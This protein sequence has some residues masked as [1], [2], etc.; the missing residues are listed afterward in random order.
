MLVIHD[1]DGSPYPVEAALARAGFEVTRVRGLTDALR[2]FAGREPDAILVDLAAPLALEA[3]RRLRRSWSAPMIVATDRDSEFD[4]AVVLEV[5]A[6][7]CVARPLDIRE[8]LARIAALLRRVGTPRQQVLTA[9]RI[10]IDM[11]AHRV[12][13]GTEEV[14]LT[15]NE[16]ALLSTLVASTGRV[17][18]R[19]ELQKRVWGVSLVGD[20]SRLDTHMK[21]LRAKIGDG[22]PDQATIT[23]VRGIGYRYRDDV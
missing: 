17:V 5:G 16:F 18:S 7:T 3:C 10:S 4:A 23:T 22:R 13:V 14:H 6:D 1:D 21:R 20:S 15:L 12:W 9:G 11:V 8:V 2:R 19:S